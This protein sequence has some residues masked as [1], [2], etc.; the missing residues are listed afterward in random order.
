MYH[1]RTEAQG[2]F[3]GV[4]E[5]SDQFLST[6]IGWPA[7]TADQSNS[8]VVNGPLSFLRTTGS[9]GVA[10]LSQYSDRLARYPY[11]TALVRST[12]AAMWKPDPLKRARQ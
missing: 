9:H 3:E 4:L 6:T 1:F 12:T 8:E 10:A 5:A 2:P 11:V 7:A